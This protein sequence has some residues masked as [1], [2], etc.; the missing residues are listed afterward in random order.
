MKK[1]EKLYEGNMR[2]KYLLFAIPLILS[3]LLSQ[4]YNF[5]NSMMIGKFIG[6][7]AFAATAVI[8]ELI[9]LLNSIFYGY[10]TGIGIYVSILFGKSEYEID[11]YIGLGLS[12]KSFFRQSVNKLKEYNQDDPVGYDFAL[13]GLGVNSKN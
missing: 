4:S 2:K 8:T 6:S 13:F 7:E 3:A 5:V 9:E 12:D 10:L 11:E 1:P